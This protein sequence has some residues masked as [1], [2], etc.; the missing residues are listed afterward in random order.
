[1]RTLNTAI[2]TAAASLI[3]LT[4]PARADVSAPPEQVYAEYAGSVFF[5]KVADIS[6]SAAF[7]DG[8]Y[9][10][11]ATFQ[12]AGLLR[13]FDDTDIEA[14]TSGYRGAQGLTPYRY[15]HTNHASNKDR[16]VGINF[17]N[18]AAIPDVNPPFGSMGEP[19]ASDEERAGALDPISVLLGVM[20]SLPADADGVCA[21]RLPVFDGK[22]RYDLRFENAGMDEVRTQGWRGEAVRC[23]AFVEPISG[24]D[25]GD[26]PSEEETAQPVTMWLAPLGDVYVPVRFRAQTQIGSINIQA[27]RVYAGEASQ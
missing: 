4:A 6:L 22:A 26:R 18:G 15:Q 17:E 10:A 5:L 23:Q 20:M 14:V 2:L 11:A 12:S 27:T 25:P 8:T 13:W 9:S 24:Y 7:Q 21:G 16:V 3:A 1:M 19:P